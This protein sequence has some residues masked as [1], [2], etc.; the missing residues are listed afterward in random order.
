MATAATIVMRETFDWPK[1]SP[2]WQADGRDLT[3][4]EA[5][6][7]QLLEFRTDDFLEEFL[8]A[9]AAPKP[10]VLAARVVPA[11]GATP[12]LKLFQPVHGCYYL[13]CASLCCRMPGFPDRAVAT[14][15]GERVFFVLR[16]RTASGEYGWTTNGTG[17]GWK[18]ASAPRTLL[19]H[20]EPLPLFPATTAAG[21]SIY[22]GYVPVASRETY[23]VPFDESPVTQAEDPRLAELDVLLQGL[24]RRGADLNETRRMSVYLLLDLWDFFFAHLPD[25]ARALRDGTPVSGAEAD[26]VAHLDTLELTL[27][28]SFTL[29]AALGDVARART[30][31]DALGDGPLP[32]PFAGSNQ[33]FLTLIDTTARRDALKDRV[34]AALGGQRPPVALGKLT[35]EP[36]DRFV[37]R[38]VYLRPQC[39]PPQP[40][41]SEASAEFDFAPFFD[42]DAPARRIQIGLPEDTSIAG[43]RKFKKGM[44]IAI[45]KQLRER[46]SHPGAKIGTFGAPPGPQIAMICSLSI[47]IVT[48]CAFILLMIMVSILDYVFRW[49]PYFHVCLPLKPGTKS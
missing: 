36:G 19:D 35:R 30:T 24:G 22:F 38:C 49:L 32:P 21:R 37:V 44:A 42:P 3:R 28:P 13:V 43:L 5:F 8:A 47:P 18:P 7:P 40:W 11:P 29:R 16:K 31:L 34:R 26:L 10:D 14:G 39:A 6:R 25:V 27:A 41:V 2:L 45:S 48:I 46:M 15:E 1:P 12:P 4:P 20:E 17:K 9:A 23:T 33:Y